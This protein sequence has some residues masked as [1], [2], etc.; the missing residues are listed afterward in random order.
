MSFFQN[1]EIF[2][3]YG[4]YEFSIAVILEDLISQKNKFQNIIRMYSWK[5]KFSEADVDNQTI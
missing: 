1:R 5:L 3:R 2:L 4:L